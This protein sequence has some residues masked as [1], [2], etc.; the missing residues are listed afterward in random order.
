MPRYRRTSTRRYTWGIGVV[1]SLLFFVI[2]LSWIV[3]G[4]VGFRFRTFSGQKVG[5]VRRSASL[6][7]F[8][9]IASL[10]IVVGLAGVIVT[11]RDFE[12]AASRKANRRTLRIEM[13]RLSSS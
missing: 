11:G 1:C 8:W 2:A 6:A 13:Q 7:L 3:E 4:R 5:E 9:S 12:S 10:G